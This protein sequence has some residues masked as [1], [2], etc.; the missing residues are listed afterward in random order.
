[1]FA[2]MVFLEKTFLILFIL[3]NIFG[4]K[5]MQFLLQIPLEVFFFFF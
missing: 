4:F 1:M 5:T 3:Q 2:F